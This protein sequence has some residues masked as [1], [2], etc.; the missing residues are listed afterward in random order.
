M[1]AVKHY[2]WRLSHVHEESSWW[3]PDTDWSILYKP[4]N[5]WCHQ[6]EMIVFL[7]III[8][9]CSVWGNEEPWSIFINIMLSLNLWTNADSV[10]CNSDACSWLI[11]VPCIVHEA[12]SFNYAI[13]KPKWSLDFS[14]VQVAEY[15]LL[16][17]D[18][19]IPMSVGDTVWSC[20]PS[21][22]TCSRVLSRRPWLSSSW[23]R[24]RTSCRFP[25]CRQRWEEEKKAARPRRLPPP[26]PP[27]PNNTRIHAPCSLVHPVHTHFHKTPLKD[28][29]RRLFS[30]DMKIC[31]Y[32]LY[33]NPPPPSIALYI[34]YLW[35]WMPW[36]CSQI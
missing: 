9:F 3:E 8:S 4:D 30:W 10:R 25:A 23:F 13:Q 27:T 17:D 16:S 21:R 5:K 1:K 12:D 18:R 28:R 36:C 11:L 29:S 24:R 22:T 26:P 19:N 7:F 31:L 32:S 20:L 33:L 35:V 15:Y 6:S 34:C 2:D 14:W